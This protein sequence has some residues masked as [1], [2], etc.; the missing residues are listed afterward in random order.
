MGTVASLLHSINEATSKENRPTVLLQLRQ[1]TSPPHS[2]SSCSFYRIL[3]LASIIHSNNST[4]VPTNNNT[5]LQT[6]YC[7]KVRPVEGRRGSTGISFLF[8]T[9]LYFIVYHASVT[10]NWILLPLNGNIIKNAFMLLHH[11]ERWKP[12]HL[13][14]VTGR[15]SYH[16]IYIRANTSVNYTSCTCFNS[17]SFIKLKYQYFYCFITRLDYHMCAQTGLLLASNTRT[18]IKTVA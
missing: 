12:L 15:K 2:P 17:A 5:K 11:N 18:V 13:H 3:Q 8:Q 6:A 9:E 4:Q 16:N 7:C 14:M 10:W 1:K